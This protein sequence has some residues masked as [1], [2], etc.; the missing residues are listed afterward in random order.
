VQKQASFI[1]CLTLHSVV[2][3]ERFYRESLL[4]R[5]DSEIPDKKNAGMT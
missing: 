4:E 1:S 2:A 5:I 3:P